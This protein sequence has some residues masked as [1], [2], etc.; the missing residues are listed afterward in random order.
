MMENRRRETRQVACD[1]CLREIPP[2]VAQTLEGPE[3]VYHF[4]GADCYEHWRAQ[5]GRRTVGLTVEG[6]T[7]DFAAA[8]ALADRLAA[9]AQGESM[10]VAWVDRARGE[11]SPKV[12]ECQKKPGWLAYAESHG[13]NLWVNINRGEYLFIYSSG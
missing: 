11:E 5:E 6:V 7:L 13:G 4:C 3:Y 8:R 9:Q 10:L 1:V 2:S 12:P